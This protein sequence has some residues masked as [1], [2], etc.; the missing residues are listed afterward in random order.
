MT[1][2]AKPVITQIAPA[3]TIDFQGNVVRQMRVTFTVG[4]HGPFDVTVPADQFTAVAV[5][6]EM[7]KIADTVNQLTP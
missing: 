1:A 7:Q 2:P 6:A 3:N 5:Q 4:T